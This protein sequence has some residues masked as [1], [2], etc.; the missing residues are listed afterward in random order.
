ME[1]VLQSD[2]LAAVLSLD[3]DRVLEPV[4]TPQ[5]FRFQPSL[6]LVIDFDE[7]KD[8]LSAMP[9]DWAYLFR[10]PKFAS[11]HDT[12][13]CFYMDVMRAVLNELYY[14][15]AVSR[16]SGI[17][18]YPTRIRHRIA[19]AEHTS[20][21]VTSQ[22]KDPVLRAL[23]EQWGCQNIRTQDYGEDWAYACALCEV[24]QSSTPAQVNY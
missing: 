18:L 5:P 11:E 16:S 9:K 8:F 24:A 21:P 1:R 20:I 3:K 2:Q 10:Q 23:A 12:L 6:T 13:K 7:Y 4:T 15:S 17:K 22:K 14:T 19:G